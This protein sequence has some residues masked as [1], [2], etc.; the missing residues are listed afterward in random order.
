MNATEIV[1]TLYRG[2]LALMDDNKIPVKLR[3]SSVVGTV[4][5]DPFDCWIGDV[6]KKALPK[7]FEVVHAGKLTTP[8]LVIRDK[9]TE[10]LLVLR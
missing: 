6:L 3:T 9:K 8:D 10:Q 5:D 1:V 7:T 2:L 4:Q